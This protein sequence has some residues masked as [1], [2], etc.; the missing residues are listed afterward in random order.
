LAS[1]DDLTGLHNLRSF[2]R[3]L[4]AMIRACRDASVPF[5]VLVLDVDR[6]KLLN[7]AHGHLAGAEA[8]RTVGRIIASQVS[9]DAVACRH[10][11]DEFVIALPRC[12]E[13]G[14]RAFAD[15]LRHA[16]WATAPVLAGQPLPVRTL[17]V[18]IGL[19]CQSFAS[20]AGSYSDVEH[21][22]EL[23][24]AADRALYQAKQLGRNHVCVA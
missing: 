15:N 16:V 24:R 20:Q 18:S 12:S 13:A 17:S 22:E 6:L 11:G 14:G 23:F 8:V 21:G 19:A 5:S 1:T 4:S 2:E 10:G 9:C 7:D 3:R